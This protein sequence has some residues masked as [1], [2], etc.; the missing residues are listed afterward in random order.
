MNTSYSTFKTWF[1]KQVAHFM[2]KTYIGIRYKNLFHEEISWT[3][4]RNIN[5]KIQWLKF[6]SDTSMWSLLSDKYR[7]RN[8]VEE[9]GLGDILVQLYGKWNKVSDIDWDS[10]PQQFVMKVNNGSGDTMICHDKT[11]IDKDEWC[12]YFN[13]KLHTKFGSI[14]AEPHY[15]IIK[16]CIIAEELLDVSQQQITSSSLVDYKI[17]CFNGKPMYIWACHNRT[18]H[19]V[20][21]MT[22]DLDWH[23]HPEYSVSKDHYILA[24]QYIPRPQSLDKMLAAAAKLSEGFPQ[25]RV[26]LYEVG[27][28]PYFGEMTFSSMG[29]L[30]DFYTADFL[31]ILGNHTNLPQNSK[32]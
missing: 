14:C 10:L 7:V 4:P 3:N 22:Y 19:G 9:K 1:W 8:Y 15:D 21:V 17:W 29:G 2:P 28:K 30:M 12:R 23:P 25:V 20:E 18:K 13:K 5:E 11:K 6:N 32:N 27:G 31:N 24:K 26:D 16:P